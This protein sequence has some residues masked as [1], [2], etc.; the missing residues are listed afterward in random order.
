MNMPPESDIPKQ[1][2]ED[3]LM[4]NLSKGVENA[5]KA[6]ANVVCDFK[7]PITDKDWKPPEGYSVFLEI[8]TPPSHGQIRF[9]FSQAALIKLYSNIMNDSTIPDNSQV[10]D[11]LGEISNVSY[12]LAKNKMNKEGFSLNMA[13]PFP[14][15][16]QDLPK[17]V[18]T[19]QKSVVQFKIFNETCF[20]EIIISA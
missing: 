10:L 9:H 3:N 19:N 15:K 11:C 1:N 14:G 20:I 8:D 6:M 12:G 17:I 18:P 5:L 4:V 16:T 7:K 13:L 2:L